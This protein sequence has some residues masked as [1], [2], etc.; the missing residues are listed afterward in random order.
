MVCGSCIVIIM[1]SNPMIF[2]RKRVAL[3]KTRAAKRFGEH[4]FL[5]REATERLADRLKDINRSFKQVLDI[6][7]HGLFAEEMAKKQCH[8]SESWKIEMDSCFRRNDEILEYKE[9]TFDL[10][11]AA[12]GLHWVNDLPGA[13]IQLRKVLKPGGLF[14]AILPGG[15]TLKELRRSFEQVEM[16]LTSGISPRVSPFVDVRDAGSLLQRAGFAM[17]VADSDM[18][19]VEYDHPLK[20][21][22]DLRGMGE[23]NGM[24]E[25]RKYF[26]PCALITKTCEYYLEHFRNNEERVVASFELV[27]LTG[28]KPN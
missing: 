25:C 24:I 8:S 12:G 20:L 7:G 11:V 28:I 2:D 22:Q 21:M 26:T 23:S 19:T 15:E 10:V 5:F 27:T 6:S 16:C 9:S 17:P 13:L 3:H 18:L 1:Q 14:L 4:D